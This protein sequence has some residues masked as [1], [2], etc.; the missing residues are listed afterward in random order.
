LGDRNRRRQANKTGWKGLDLFYIGIAFFLLLNV[1][2]G[3]ARVIRGPAPADRLLGV[4]L[5]G[6]TGVAVML[7][8]AEGLGKPDLR[9][10][11]LVFALLA[12]LATVAF[13]KREDSAAEDLEP[14]RSGGDETTS[15]LGS[16][17][18]SKISQ[19]KTGEET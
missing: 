12:V 9:N 8:L 3:L 2:V 13:V 1:L 4:L 5:F 10:I 19:G 7:L 18:G 15:S 11:A 17:P 6:S 14:L 16:K